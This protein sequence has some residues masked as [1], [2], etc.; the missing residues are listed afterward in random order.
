MKDPGMEEMKDR[1]G[2]APPRYCSVLPE[3]ARENK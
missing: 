2:N 1:G 3:Q